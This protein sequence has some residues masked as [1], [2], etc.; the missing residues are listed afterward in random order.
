MDSGTRTT[1]QNGGRAGTSTY[2]TPNGWRL[3]ASVNTYSNGNFYW[4]SNL[5]DGSHSCDTQTC[6]KRDRP[7][8]ELAH[9]CYWLA[10][11]GSSGSLTLT[12]P[13]MTAVKYLKLDPLYRGDS[14]V[15][16]FKV[17]V[18]GLDITPHDFKSKISQYKARHNWGSCGHPHGW[19]QKGLGG[20][21]LNP[22]CGG[23][24]KIPVDR[25]VRQVKIEITEVS[26]HL[27]FGE[28]EIYQDNTAACLAEANSKSAAEDEAETN[29]Y[30]Q[31]PDNTATILDSG[32]KITETDGGIGGK[33]SYTSPK[34]WVLSSNIPTYSNGK[35]YWLSNM[36]DGSTSC[37][38][39]TCRH[40]WGSCGHPDG[41]CQK[42]L[43]G[44]SLNPVGCGEHLK[45]P[46]KKVLKQIQIHITE[47]DG[48]IGFGEIALYGIDESLC[49]AI[50]AGSGAIDRVEKLESNF[51]LISTHVT[52]LQHNLSE[53]HAM[54][55]ALES[56]YSSL[57]LHVTKLE[58]EIE[59]LRSAI[60]ESFRLGA[61][62]SSLP[63]RE[64]VPIPGACDPNNDRSNI[65]EPAIESNN[66]NIEVSLP[67]CHQLSINDQ[68]VMTANEIAAFVS[69]FVKNLFKAALEKSN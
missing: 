63:D 1:E 44:Q 33:K 32:T 17:Y 11:G 40:N 50:S 61:G 36:L 13:K 6:S 9:N 66:G 39:Q 60:R 37:D 47:V 53:A 57:N 10:A 15:N 62:L 22:S 18:D 30:A 55:K 28:I 51:S 24:I 45:V 34:N 35:F 19:C 5:L 42:G 3:D 16:N 8:T 41:W 2:T 59:T 7:T 25:T 46:V 69:N 12:L 21:G 38:T 54:I 65:K 68:W 4:L 43:S 52:T 48:H 67:P 20:Q 29:R 56:N 31:C 23:F 26:S 27:G 58:A 49:K 64:N 14:A